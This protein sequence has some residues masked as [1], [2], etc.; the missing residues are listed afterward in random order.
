MWERPKG[1]FSSAH[2]TRAATRRMLVKPAS[3]RALWKRLFSS[4]QYPPRKAW[5]SLSYTSF[6]A[7]RDT[8]ANNVSRVSKKKKN[9]VHMLDHQLPE[10]THTHGGATHPH[11]LPL[12]WQQRLG[13]PN[14]LE[15]RLKWERHTRHACNQKRRRKKNEV[16]TVN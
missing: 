11:V 5:I 10:E 12:R 7:N 2:N 9:A 6:G 4:K 16:K 8:A 13:C 14:A 3:R 15:V 1:E